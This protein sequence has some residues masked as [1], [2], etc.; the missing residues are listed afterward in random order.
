MIYGDLSNCPD[1]SRGLPSDYME[2]GMACYMAFIAAKGYHD[3]PTWEALVWSD[4]YSWCE[5]ARAA[6][7]T[8]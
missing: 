1:G 4:Q 7:N 5:A 3:E 2:C 6:R 8:K